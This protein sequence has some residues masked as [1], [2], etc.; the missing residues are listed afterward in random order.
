MTI[1]I[2][3]A[4]I[5]RTAEDVIE[6]TRQYLAH[7]SPE[8]LALIPRKCRPHWI[9]SPEDIEYYAG[10]LRAE[11]SR[12]TDEHL[13]VPEELVDMRDFFSR[14]AC[15]LSLLHIKD[16]GADVTIP[17]EVGAVDR[18]PPEVAGKH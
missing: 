6:A 15:V 4:A 17:R 2:E 7:W 3:L 12:R 11:H 8:R 13:G 5:A 10:R 16:G 1:R 18:R 14:A 9:G